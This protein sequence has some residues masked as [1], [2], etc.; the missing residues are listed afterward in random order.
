MSAE[1]AHHREMRVFGRAEEQMLD[2]MATWQQVVVMK[3]GVGSHVTQTGDEAIEGTEVIAENEMAVGLA[4]DLL[5]QRILGLVGRFDQRDGT[6]PLL[7]GKGRN[8]AP[9]VFRPLPI[10]DDHFDDRLGP[11][12]PAAARDR[13]LRRFPAGHGR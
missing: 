7:L 6:E 11:A 12:A 3:Q 10:D 13:V 4:Q 2:G 1:F 9:D 8:D 5:G